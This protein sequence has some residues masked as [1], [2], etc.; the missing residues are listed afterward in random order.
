[1]GSPIQDLAQTVSK[2]YSQFPFYKPQLYCNLGNIIQISVTDNTD[3]ISFY[4]HKLQLIFY[5]PQRSLSYLKHNNKQSNPRL[6]IGLWILKMDGCCY[7]S[8]LETFPH[9][10][11]ILS[12]TETSLET[13]FK[14]LQMNIQKN[15]QTQRHCKYEM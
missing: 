15:F 13:K 10:F 12:I 4:R 11:I 9:M 2:S 3:N 5:W 6:N 7:L 14:L 1:M 8:F